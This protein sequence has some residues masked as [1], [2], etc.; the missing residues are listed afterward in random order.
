MLRRRFTIVALVLVAA[1]GVVA[2]QGGGQKANNSSGTST[3]S[4]FQ[5]D[6]NA[7]D[8][9]FSP[10]EKD[11]SIFTAATA[12]SSRLSVSL[13]KAKLKAKRE[14]A[15]SLRSTLEGQRDRYVEEIGN[16]GGDKETVTREQYQDFMREMV[17]EEL[18]GVRL[19][20]KGIIR[21]G[22][23]YRAYV[24][25][26]LTMEDLRGKLSGKEELK[27]RFNAKKFEEDMNKNLDEL[28]KRRQKKMTQ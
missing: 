5:S 4:E 13:N 10:P 7:P 8:W 22:G 17:A 14:L 28:R 20:E 3:S 26:E 18:T 15:A 21:E 6:I 27:T 16:T 12:K 11:G 24:L 1:F 2:C 9:F 19:A 25:M 23:G